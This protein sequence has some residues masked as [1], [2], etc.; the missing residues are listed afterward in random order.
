[1]NRPVVG[2]ATATNALPRCRKTSMIRI[3]DQPSANNALDPTPSVVPAGRAAHR[4][5]PLLRP[6]PTKND[7]SLKSLIRAGSTNVEGSRGHGSLSF[8][9]HS[10]AAADQRRDWSGG[11]G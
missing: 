3:G 11:V 6:F 9:L 8:A 1:M 7:F 4:G 10:Q 2:G 5:L